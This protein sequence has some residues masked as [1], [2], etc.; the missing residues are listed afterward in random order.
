MRHTAASWLMQDRTDPSIA[1]AG[2]PRTQAAVFAMQPGILERS[3]PCLVAADR[4]LS[5]LPVIDF[6]DMIRIDMLTSPRGFVPD[7][8]HYN[9]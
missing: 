4:S 2:L 1:G 3:P 6:P 9:R 5:L 7:A 8:T